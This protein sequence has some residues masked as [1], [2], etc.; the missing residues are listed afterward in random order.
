MHLIV[1]SDYQLKYLYKSSNVQTIKDLWA[2]FTLTSCSCFDFSVRV[3]LDVCDSQ[4][5]STKTTKIL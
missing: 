4:S 2:V 3:S 1:F 5:R